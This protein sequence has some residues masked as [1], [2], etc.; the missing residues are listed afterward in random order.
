MSAI[1]DFIK[2]HRTERGLSRNALAQKA[3]ISHTEIHRIETGERK[4]PS[5]KTLIALAV[6]LDIPQEEV[7]KVAGY[8]PSGD[9][10]SVDTLFPELKSQ[11]QKET[12]EKIADVLSVKPA[13]LFDENGCPEN[14]IVADKGALAHELGEILY[15]KIRADIVKDIECVLCRA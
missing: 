6:A 13:V 2:K 12:I 5:L 15:T 9:Q 11:K 1:G 4:E 7:L 3:G 8:A 10:E 14:A